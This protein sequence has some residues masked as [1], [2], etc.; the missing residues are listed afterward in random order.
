MYL[1]HFFLNQRYLR[2]SLGVLYINCDCDTNIYFL[3][4]CTLIKQKILKIVIF[5]FIKGN[6]VQ[7]TTKTIQVKLFENT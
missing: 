3:F 2:K 1:F 6:I 7:K 4:N 5:I